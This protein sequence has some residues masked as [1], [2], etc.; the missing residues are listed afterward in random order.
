ME[1]IKKKSNSRV[2][3]VS[4]TNSVPIFNPSFE[5]FFV[6]ITLLKAFSWEGRKQKS[7]DNNISI[8]RSKNQGRTIY[9]EGCSASASTE[10]ISLEKHQREKQ[11]FI[12]RTN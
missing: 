9:R 3:E 7:D 10:V 5:G 11:I 12:F 6:K 2:T 4:K 1:S 8:S